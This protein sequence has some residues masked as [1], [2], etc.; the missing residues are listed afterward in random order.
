V[1][2]RVTELVIAGDSVL[3]VAE[4]GSLPLQVEARDARG[5]RIP[6]PGLRV[7]VA[8][9]AI[10]AIDSSGHLRAI[11]PGSTTVS[12]T[13]ADLLVQ[14]R[15]EVITVPAS[16]TLSGGG[17]QRAGA[18]GRLPA[19]VAVQVVSRSGRPVPQ[20]PVLFDGSAS[21]GQLTPDTATSDSAGVA[22]VRWTLGARPGRQQMLVAVPGIDS[23]L[24]VTAEADPLPAATRVSVQADSLFGQVVEPLAQPVAVQLT[25]TSGV[26]LGDVPVAWKALDGGEAVAVSART[27][28]LGVAQAR[29]TL[30]RRAGR[31][32]L[33]VQVGNPR[34]FPPRIVTVEARPAT[35][36]QLTISAGD[37]QQGTV[38]RPIPSKVVLEVSDSLGNPVPDVPVEFHRTGRTAGD[39]V[40][41]SGK[42]GRIRL[43]WTLARIAGPDG[44]IAHLTDGAD[45]VRVTATARPGAADTVRFIDPPATA[46]AGR[47]AAT[48]VRL[49][50]ADRYGNPVPGS[51]VGLGATA[52]K[53]SRTRATTDSNGVATVRWTP[54]AVAGTQ[55]L[56]A[57]VSGSG[58]RAR[59]AVKVTAP[60]PASGRRRRK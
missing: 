52:G 12:A 41:R 11:T 15:V 37:G 47:T 51:A 49:R 29:W 4:G 43:R 31:Q 60:A 40:I 53:L 46:V 6:A 30:G 7:N 38:G 39:S 32:R 1:L 20:V 17:G 25:D 23:P 50:V 45:S 34:S 58:V 18:G 5:N 19:S 27:D 56:T 54:G 42:D 9:E 22:R 13:F 3:R 26:A 21:G 57:T 2:P 33:Q 48:T 10:A 36:R 24:V 16:L 35:A 8:D 14:R 59:H 28:S 55:T 44:F